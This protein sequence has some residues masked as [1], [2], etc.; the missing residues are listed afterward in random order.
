MLIRVID[1]NGTKIQVYEN[2]NHTGEAIVFLHPQGSSSKIWR[3]VDSYFDRYHVILIDLRGQGESERAISG[4]DIETQCQDILTVLEAVGVAKAHFVGNSLGGDIATAFAAMHPEIVLSLT[5]IDSGM[6]DY[7]GVDGERP[8]TKEE[9]LAEFRNREIKSFASKKEMLQYVE[10]VF[11]TE[12][13][14][15]YF[16]EWFKFVSIYE[17]QDGRFSYQIPVH[18]N[19]QIM[20][21]VCELKYKALYQGIECPI[22]FLPAEKE[23]HLHTKLSY[24]EEA[25]KYTETWTKIIPGSQHLM[26]LNQLDEVCHEIREFIQS[27]STL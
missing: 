15:S 23:D 10:S 8:L 20:S 2:G 4:Y 14:D 6:I 5:N 16:E 3:G 22:L 1:N 24:I 13:W 27:T 26:I 21:M 25:N 12:I 11:P 7:I 19:V 18:I 9:V 17:L